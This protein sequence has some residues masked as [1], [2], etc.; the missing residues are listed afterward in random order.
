MFDYR[1][2]AKYVQSDNSKNFGHDS[3]KSD[4]VKWSSTPNRR[5][6]QV[7]RVKF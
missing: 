5:C 3:M 4:A 7:D 2:W 1:N 6:M